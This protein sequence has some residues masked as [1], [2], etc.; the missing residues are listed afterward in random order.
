M[1][2]DTILP[3]EPRVRVYKVLLN[4]T[5]TNAPVPRVLQ[6]TFDNTP[7]WTRISAG[8]YRLTLTGAFPRDKR[9][10]FISQ[11]SP[12]GQVGIGNWNSAADID[13]YT[14]DDNTFNYKDDILIDT[15]FTLE[16]YT[17]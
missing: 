17:D 5:S 13:I 6:N 15:P 1:Q 4:Q 10:A 8:R 3:K 14:Y 12:T 7:V 2:P 9:L 16:V 11:R